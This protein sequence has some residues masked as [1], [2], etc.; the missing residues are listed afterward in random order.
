MYEQLRRD[1]P[2]SAIIQAFQVLVKQI[3]SESE[4][5]INLWRGNL[6]DC[7]CLDMPLFGPSAIGWHTIFRNSIFLAMSWL[8]F[9]LSAP[10]P[11]TNS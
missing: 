2:Y 4:D 7:G 3:L 5:R 11:K 6:I 10:A 9:Y 8:V 1:K